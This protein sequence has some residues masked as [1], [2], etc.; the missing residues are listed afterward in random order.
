MQESESLD[1]NDGVQKTVPLPQHQKKSPPLTTNNYDTVWNNDANKNDVKD[2]EPDLPTQE[3]S[4]Y[5]N[6]QCTGKGNQLFFFCFDRALFLES[7]IF[8]NS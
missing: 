2:T 4:S 6:L 1:Q 5:V 8:P 7:C 3:N